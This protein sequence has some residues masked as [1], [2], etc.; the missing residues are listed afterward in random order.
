MSS[1]A[2]MPCRATSGICRLGIDVGDIVAIDPQPEFLHNGYIV[3]RHLDN[4]AGVADDARRPQ[5]AGRGRA[6]AP[7]RHRTGCSRSRRRSAS[8]RPPR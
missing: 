6:S 1:C 2:S 4:K 3:S 8:A 7:R 5:G